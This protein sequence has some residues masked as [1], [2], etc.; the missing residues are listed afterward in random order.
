MNDTPNC[1]IC[2]NKVEEKINPV[3][4]TVYWNQG[5]SASPVA[6]GRCCLRCNAFLVV[7]ARLRARAAV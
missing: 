5:E 6:E 1:V 7:P 3:D 4:G 2:G